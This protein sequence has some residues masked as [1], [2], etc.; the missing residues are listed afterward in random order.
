MNAVAKDIISISL[1]GDGVVGALIPT[2]HARRYVTGPGAWRAAMRLFAERPG[3]T[4]SLALVE[5][6]AGV[7]LAVRDR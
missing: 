1:I 7:R 6:F 3:L 2:R 4:R 5:L